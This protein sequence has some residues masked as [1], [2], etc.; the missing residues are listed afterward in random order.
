MK[1][2]LTERIK[3]LEL[4]IKNQVHTHKVHLADLAKKHSDE[5]CKL[6]DV[7]KSIEE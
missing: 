4:N 1:K 6:K 2:N 7:I 5:L 3:E